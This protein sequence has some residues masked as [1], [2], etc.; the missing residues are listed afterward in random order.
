M[1]PAGIDGVYGWETF[2]FIWTEER[3]LR[4]FENRVLKKI[5]F[6]SKLSRCVMK[7]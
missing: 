1:T 4:T 2:C 3:K 7:Y 6:S 5:F